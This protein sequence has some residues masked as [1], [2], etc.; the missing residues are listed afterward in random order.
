MAE[1]SIRTV[2]TDL[3][4]LKYVPNYP[5]YTPWGTIQMPKPMDW[6]KEYNE[7]DGIMLSGRLQNNLT[8]G[9]MPALDLNIDWHRNV[10]KKYVDL[11]NKLAKDLLT[12]DKTRSI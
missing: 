9:F 1:K 10:Y 11:K 12:G 8:P 2:A 4:I 3:G 6:S 5:T 7:E